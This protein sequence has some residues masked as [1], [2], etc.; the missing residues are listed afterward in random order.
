MKKINLFVLFFCL[1]Q[2]LANADN[3]KTLSL[4]RVTGNIYSI[5]GPITNRTKENLGNSGAKYVF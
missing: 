3:V 2:T 1:L 5:V 4:K